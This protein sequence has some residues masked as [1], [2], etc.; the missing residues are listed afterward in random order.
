MSEDGRIQP[1]PISRRCRWTLRCC[2]PSRAQEVA[3]RAPFTRT[4]GG[5][6]SRATAPP[7]EAVYG[8]IGIDFVADGPPA[9]GC[10]Q[11]WRPLSICLLAHHSLAAPVKAPVGESQ[12]V[13]SG[14]LE[15]AGC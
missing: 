4:R 11:E 13:S 15:I 5:A 2:G 7:C 1:E 14:T 6:G 9:A 8:E 10:V 3:P 12:K